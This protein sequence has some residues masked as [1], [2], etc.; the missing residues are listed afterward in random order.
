M[1]PELSDLIAAVPPDRLAEIIASLPPNVAKALLDDPAITQA[2][3]PE[4][5]SLVDLGY[6]LIHDFTTRP[7]I[8]YLAGV[9]S[10]AVRN[11]EQGQSQY[12]T[13]ELPPRAGKSTVAT[14]LT[15]AWLLA[16]YPQWPLALISH[17]SGLSTNWGRQIRRWVEAGLL[18][19][20][21]VARDAGAVKEWQTS[22]GGGVL[23]ISTRE[24]F[25]GRGAKVL[26]VDDPHKDFADAHSA[27]KRNEVWE[28]WKSVAYTRLHHPA[29]VMVVQTRWHEDDLIGRLLSEKYE[30]DPADWQRIKV[31]AIAEENDVL[32]RAVGQ[33]LLSPII[34]EDEAQALVRW[35]EVKTVVGAYTWNAMYQQN[36]TPPDGRIVSRDW[37]RYYDTAP[38]TF[39][40]VLQS[41]DLAFDKSDTSSF[42]VGQVWGRKGA[43]KYLLDQYRE[44][45]DFVQTI[46][47]IEQMS[48]KWPQ[49][50]LK[51]VERKANGAAVLSTL[52]NKVSGL[53]PVNPQGSKLARLHAV[54][55]Q[56]EAGN[57]HL[58]TTAQWTRDVVEELVGF[59]SHAHDDQVDALTQAL[60]RL[61]TQQRRPKA[62][63]SVF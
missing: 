63:V 60:E 24:S 9:L 44:R 43:D 34:D 25:T 38:G 51:L 46:A 2:T 1:Q 59:P 58:P 13:V 17:D 6:R 7:H 41:W 35:Q 45:S 29:L 57:V 19:G 62:K 8:N 5:G 42:V 18:P 56:L 22:E 40:E 27:H 36:P 30:G 21:E 4:V 47:A 3:T 50:Q 55:P 10:E 52:R 20:V 37:L 53:V 49:A 26:V 11:V 32:G 28:W 61:G 15:P 33:P 23:S 14:Q 31:P 16:K 54:S 48:A 12:L 39:D